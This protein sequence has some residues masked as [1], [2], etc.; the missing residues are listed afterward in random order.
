MNHTIAPEIYYRTP[1]KIDWGNWHAAHREIGQKGEELVVDLEKN[2]LNIMKSE[3]LA[4]SISH[5]GDWH[6]YDILSFFPDGREKYID[7]KT[8][9]KDID[10]PYL[11]SRNELIFLANNRNNAF[12]YRVSIR[13]REFP[14]LKVYTFSEVMESQILPTQY[15]VQSQL[16]AA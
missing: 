9:V 12:I 16:Q 5:R 14:R 15:K 3:K 11:L 4:D 10:E 8:T 6:G 7:V 2:Y 13:D 1:R